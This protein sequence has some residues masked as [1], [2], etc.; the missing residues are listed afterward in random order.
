MWWPAQHTL[1]VADLHLGKATAFSARGLPLAARIGQDVARADLELLASLLA[2][3]RASRLVIL[4]DLLHAPESR[5]ACVLQAFADWRAS[6]PAADVRILLIRGNHDDRAGDPP[7]S[8]RI[9]CHDEGLLDGPFVLCHTPRH[10]ERGYVLCGHLHPAAT[11]RGP[12]RIERSPCFVIGS[13]SAVFPAF[14]RFTGGSSVHASP[15]D[16]ILAAGDGA[17][18]DVT[19]LVQAGSSASVKGTRRQTR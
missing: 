9:Q 18:I 6:R 19:S 15:G 8:W 3:S 2:R 1:F 13:R 12:G 14:G 5:Q 10:D 7:A 4:G 17:V 11:L 16:R